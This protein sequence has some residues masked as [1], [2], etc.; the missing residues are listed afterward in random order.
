MDMSSVITTIYL[1]ITRQSNPPISQFETDCV[2]NSRVSRQCSHA[3]T[4]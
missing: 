2:T 4:G 1:V 3:I